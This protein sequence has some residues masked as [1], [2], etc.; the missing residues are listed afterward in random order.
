MYRILV[1]RVTGSF[2]WFFVPADKLANMAHF[3]CD[4]TLSGRTNA[5]VWTAS[6]VKL[7]TVSCENILE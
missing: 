1:S 6:N 5:V 3:F 4:E 7:T 2:Y